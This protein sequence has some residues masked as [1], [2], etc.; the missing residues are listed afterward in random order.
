MLVPVLLPVS[1]LV[2]VHVPGLVLV[3]LLVL[4]LVLLGLVLVLA[5]LRILDSFLRLFISLCLGLPSMPTRYLFCIRAL[6][7]LYCKTCLTSLYT[8]CAVLHYV[9]C[10][11]VCYAAL[12]HCGMSGTFSTSPL[13]L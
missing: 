7:C 6:F 9:Q 10:C 13:R 11:A 1:V 8:A 2:L 5:L 12:L 4:V 3:V